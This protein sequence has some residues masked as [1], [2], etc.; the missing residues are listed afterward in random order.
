MNQ[1]A[2]PKR[3][4]GF[5]LIELVTALVLT[6]VLLSLVAP[7]MDAYI[8]R[9][10]TRR[11]L[12]RVAGDISHARLLAVQ[13]GRRIW[14]RMDPSG[15]YSVDSV[16]ASGDTLPIKT[17]DLRQDYG[18]VTMT[19]LS[20]LEFSSRGL[21]SNLAGDGDAYVKVVTPGYRDSLFVSPAGRIYRAY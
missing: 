8:T 12:D 17:V 14:I 7:K 13:N 21:V 20:R 4:A 15:S 16:S 9:Q 19:G 11:S 10:K 6:G 1:P 5:S 2:A 3:T 18:E